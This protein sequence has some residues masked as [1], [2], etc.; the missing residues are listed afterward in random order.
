MKTAIH[1]VKQKTQCQKNQLFDQSAP[2]SRFDFDEIVAFDQ[3]AESQHLRGALRSGA[4]DGH[5]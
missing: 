2:E 5:E 1:A 4:L 3:D